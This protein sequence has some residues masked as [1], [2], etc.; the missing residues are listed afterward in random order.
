M[1]R[2]ATFRSLDSHRGQCREAGHPLLLFPKKLGNASNI[3]TRRGR[4]R[5]GGGKRNATGAW[6]RRRYPSIFATVRNTRGGVGSP[7]IGAVCLAWGLPKYQSPL[8]N[9]I[10]YVCL[11]VYETRQF[12]AGFEYRYRAIEFRVNRLSFSRFGP[13]ISSG[14]RNDPVNGVFRLDIFLSKL[15]RVEN[16]SQPTLILVDPIF[17]DPVLYF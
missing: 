8:A 16:F 9:N 3:I 10:V 11:G 4:R 14:G 13:Q 7:F 15:S 2:C 1:V 12:F 17:H 6:K 5:G